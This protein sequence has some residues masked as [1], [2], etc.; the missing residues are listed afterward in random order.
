MCN[1]VQEDAMLSAKDFALFCY[2]FFPF[3]ELVDYIWEDG[4]GASSCCSQVL[5]FLCSVILG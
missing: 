5:D 3:G 1:R 2:Y 4:L